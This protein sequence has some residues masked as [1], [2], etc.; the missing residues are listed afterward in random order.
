M[1]AAK[2]LFAG[3]PD[4][5][6]E[7]LRAL[8]KAG[9]IPAAVLTQPDRPA[10][11]GR[12]VT[13][14]PVK[15]FAVKHD[16]PVWQPETLK[17]NDVIAQVSQ[18]KP[19]LIIVAAYGLLFPQAVL[20]IPVRGCVNVHASLLP[21]WRGAA[22]IQAAIL[23]GDAETGITLMQ[24]EAGLDSGP[25]LASAAIAIRAVETA[26]ELHDR[27]AVLGGEHL[28]TRIG[29]DVNEGPGVNNSPVLSDG[30]VDFPRDRKNHEFVR[31]I[32]KVRSGAGVLGHHAEVEGFALDNGP[33]GRREVGVRFF[34]PKSSNL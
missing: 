15:Q 23:A 3:T 22:P 10:G 14:S 24:M 5:A 19:D 31:M 26:G 7:S 34:S 12:Q 21:L 32:V 29:R 6:L 8:H 33:P 2:L 4:F 27:L 9:S 17:D 28:M 18:A 13:E 20:D 30:R 16:I 25:V 11:R 1:S